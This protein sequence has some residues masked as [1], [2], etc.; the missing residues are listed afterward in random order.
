MSGISPQPRVSFGAFEV[1]PRT[2][3]LRKSGIR[4]K[5]HEKP[6]QLLL[7]LLDHPGEVVTRK[8][9]QLRLWPRE[10]FV[11]FEN[12][13]NNAIGRLREALGD[14]AESPRF[15]ETIPRHGYRF[16]Q[17][18]S[19][20]V[21][22]SRVSSS[23]K[24]WTLILASG[25]AVLIAGVLGTFFGRPSAAT[26][27]SIAVL[28]FRN[29]GTGTADDYFAAGMTDAVTTDLA[30]SSISKVVSETSVARFKNTKAAI[31]EIA[32]ALG[33]DAVVE[34]AVLQEGGR[35]RI[36]VQLIR[37]DTDRHIWAESYE[38]QLTDILA[39]QDQVAGG[40]A[41]AIGLKLSPGPAR[42]ISS[43]PQVNASAYQAY[44]EG[45]YYAQE[46]NDQFFRAKGYLEQ[47][48]QLDPSFAP[49]Y[50]GLSDYYFKMSDNSMPSKEA[51]PKCK[52]YAEQ[53]LR[54]DP[55]SP[56]GHLSL[57]NFYFVNWNWSGANQEYQ[58]AIA[59]APGLAPA[60]EW[61]A[62]YL[63]VMGRKARSLEEAQRAVELDPLYPHAHNTLA[64]AA[65]LSG[66]YG[67][68]LEECH[69]VLE[70][71][72]SGPGGLACMVQDLMYTGKFREALGEVQKA[73]ALT[74]RD[75]GF[76]SLGAIAYAD[77]G[78][79]EQANKLVEE[80]KADGKRQYVSPSLL[81]VAFAAMGRKKEALDDLEECYK[82]HDTA[83][84]FLKIDPFWD[85][86]RRD[87]RFQKLLLQM[88]YPK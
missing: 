49:A 62:T 83:L 80:I 26:V 1:D 44:L 85:P 65:F 56:E 48:I 27:Q 32:R 47:A 5:L 23:F 68:A 86:L 54:L 22:S 72:P 17:E 74:H 4:I 59:L 82:L 18:V 71:E 81:A 61:Y 29:L 78:Q 2:G 9:L 40:V 31:P 55:N 88:N 53:A 58:R 11:E 39:L 73:I 28:P 84:M 41:S 6:F 7:A 46:A 35:V 36:T 25:A 8:E 21:P 51:L 42:R 60:H 57:A 16:L 14:T 50:A 43:S 20:S 79:M 24:R 37:A 3:E 15:I 10:T 33:V 38:R 75:P 87:P 67:R 64:G 76:L 13:L 70:L 69:Q 45:H 77:L 66:E 52:N 63:D 12:G 19:G 30:E 34:G